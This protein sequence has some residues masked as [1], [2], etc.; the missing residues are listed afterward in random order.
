MPQYFNLDISQSV[1]LNKTAAK[2][3]ELLQRPV[4]WPVANEID[5]EDRAKPSTSAEEERARTEFG[6][7]RF[8]ANL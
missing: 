6:H 4:L 2:L 1:R 5:D 7:R 8:K 3:V